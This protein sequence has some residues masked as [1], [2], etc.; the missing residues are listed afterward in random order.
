[1]RQVFLYAISHLD[2]LKM[3]QNL[4]LGDLEIFA[5]PLFE[6]ALFNIM[7]NVLEHGMSATEVTLRFEQ[8]PES[9]LLIIE[10][11]GVGIAPEEKNMIFDR[12]YGKGSGLGLFLVREVLSITGMTIRETGTRGKGTRF[13]VTVPHGAFQQTK[14][15]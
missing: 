7:E 13:E 8:K 12:G 1:V 4:Q 14:G 9:L 11:N 15:Q 10:D 6:K 2:F 5:D 3:K